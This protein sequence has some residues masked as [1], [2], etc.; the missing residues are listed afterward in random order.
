MSFKRKQQNKVKHKMQPNY[1]HQ[2]K[3]PNSNPISAISPISPCSAMPHQIPS[4]SIKTA[5]FLILTLFTLSSIPTFQSSSINQYLEQKAQLQQNNK[6][7]NLVA[8]QQPKRFTNADS[9]HK[10][11]PFYSISATNINHRAFLSGFASDTKKIKK[12]FNTDRGGEWF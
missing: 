8:Q 3:P 11:T 2:W 7:L 5:K 6:A 9:I 12:P 1:K 10:E 4:I